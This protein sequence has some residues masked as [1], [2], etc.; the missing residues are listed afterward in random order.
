MSCATEY[1]CQAFAVIPP[2]VDNMISLYLLP[3]RERQAQAVAALGP[4]RKELLLRRYLAGNADS[5][6]TITLDGSLRIG[7]SSGGRE[8]FV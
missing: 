2:Q 6:I 3:N 1:A 5:V 4:R 8:D 7:Q